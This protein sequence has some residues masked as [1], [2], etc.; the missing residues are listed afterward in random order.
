M[1]QLNNDS[2][3]QVDLVRP[4]FYKRS[5]FVEHQ[6][7]GIYLF[8]PHLTSKSPIGCDM[9]NMMSFSKLKLVGYRNDRLSIPRANKKKILLL[10][11]VKTMTRD[12]LKIPGKSIRVINSL[13]SI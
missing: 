5:I 7:R 11:M 13:F 12:R 2:N 1:I 3:N 4:L 9:C 10:T 6:K 8:Q